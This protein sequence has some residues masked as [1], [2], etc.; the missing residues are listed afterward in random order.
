M[1]KIYFLF[2]L[3]LMGF[4]STQGQLKIN[5]GAGI[6]SGLHL[7]TEGL[8]Y[9]IDRYNE[10][11]PH[12]STQMKHP[13]F[14]AGLNF[15][16]DVY[17]PKFLMNVEGITRR[18]HVMAESTT[19][20]FTRDLR[21]SVTSLNYGIGYRVLSIGDDVSGLYLGANFS[22]IALRNSTRIYDIG[23]KIPPYSPIRRDFTSGLVPFVQYTTKLIVIKFYYQI[24]MFPMPD[25]YRANTALNPSSWQ[26]DP[27][28]LQKGKTSSIGLC[29]R[30]DLYKFRGKK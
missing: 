22:L 1:R 23:A 6:N 16:A 8:S 25:Y 18:S 26:N 2:A 21:Y 20:N 3:A 12:L 7:K 5:F 15:S 10:T 9:V 27:L 11:R 30:Y 19:N 13:K 24:M 14:F 28:D 17:F 29:V 4:N